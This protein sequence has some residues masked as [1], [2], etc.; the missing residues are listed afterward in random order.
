MPLRFFFVNVLP[1]RKEIV[2]LQQK[3]WQID[4]KMKTKTEILRL[5]KL[6]KPI[7]KSKYGL[8]RIGIFGSVARGEQTEHSDVDVCYDGRVPSLLTI[9]RIQSD[10]EQMFDCHVDLVRIRKDVNSLL[11]QR[12]KKE[13]L[14]V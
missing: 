10:L 2:T 1:F 6:Y 9:D 13:G 12:I 14:Y 7:A 11:Q 5:L 3:T 4:V 8:T